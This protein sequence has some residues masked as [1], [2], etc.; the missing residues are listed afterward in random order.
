MLPL[1]TSVIH[2]HFCILMH[3]Y[4]RRP[5]PPFFVSR[6]LAAAMK[7][8]IVLA[9]LAALAAAGEHK[10]HRPVVDKL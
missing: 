10:P 4:K 7:C 3:T 2:M 6:S 8:F 5:L 1:A 9:A